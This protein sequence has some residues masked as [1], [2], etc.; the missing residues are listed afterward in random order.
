MSHIAARAAASFLLLASAALFVAASAQRWWPACPRGRFDTAACLR[1]QDHE[2]DYLSVSAPW[3][4]L[5]DAA[6]YAGV[7]MF[8]LAGAA[9][10]LPFVL[11][12]RALR[13]QVPI[14]VM[15][16]GSLT[17]LGVEVWWSGVTGQPQTAPGSSAAALVWALGVPLLLGAWWLR[18]SMRADGDGMRW[19]SALAGA[20]MAAAPLPVLLLGPLAVGYVSHDTAPWS[21]AVIAVPLAVAA[22]LVWKV[23]RATRPRSAARPPTRPTTA[24][25]APR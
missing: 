9:A 17:I 10:V 4:S 21:D 24:A 19:T 22:L 20:L 2:F 3:T 23:P 16:A 5:G 11:A 25:P 7:G 6:Q 13:F 8:L 14:A 18:E 1:L 12:G 15:V